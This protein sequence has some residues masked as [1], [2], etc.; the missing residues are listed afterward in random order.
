MTGNKTWSREGDEEHRAQAL[1][2]TH[3]A[4]DKL[5][6]PF[7]ISMQWEQCK[8]HQQTCDSFI[9]FK[10]LKK[11][12]KASHL[13]PSHLFHLFLNHLVCVAQVAEFMPVNS[14]AD[15]FKNPNT[16]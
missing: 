16:A 3:R 5:L 1:L 8:R 11:K 12:R 4:L 14:W 2:P 9:L 13:F 6:F 7:V 10:K 15:A